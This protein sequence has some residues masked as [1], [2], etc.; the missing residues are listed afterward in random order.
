MSRIIA[1][2]VTL[3]L[4]GCTSSLGRYRLVELPSLASSGVSVL[5][6]WD[7]PG[8]WENGGEVVSIHIFG[9][10][11]V[12]GELAGPAA[13]AYAGHEIGRGS[14]DNNNS[15]TVNAPGSGGPP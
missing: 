8:G 12:L 14:S 9:G 4:A 5:E 3:T 15:T 6:I 10:G 13:I 2:I 1:L 11:S 7:R